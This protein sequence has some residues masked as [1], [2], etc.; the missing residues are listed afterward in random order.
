MKGVI[1]L[2]NRSTCTLGNIVNSH[3]SIVR[4]GDKLVSYRWVKFGNMRWMGGWRY[5]DK[6]I[7]RLVCVKDGDKTQGIGSD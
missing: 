1:K 3:D 7:S 6:K 5:T 4:A 2:D